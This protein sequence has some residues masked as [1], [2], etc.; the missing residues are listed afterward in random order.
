MIVGAVI[1][2]AMIIPQIV[3]QIAIGGTAAVGLIWPAW[4]IILPACIV[5]LILAFSAVIIG[6]T[7]TRSKTLTRRSSYVTITGAAVLCTLAPVTYWLG[8]AM[9]AIGVGPA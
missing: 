6:I 5:V 1:E 7:E 9:S 2:A 4:P 8:W 3:I